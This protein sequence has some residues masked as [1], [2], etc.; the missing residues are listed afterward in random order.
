M[1]NNQHALSAPPAPLR[2]SKRLKLVRAAQEK[3]QPK[4]NETLAALPKT[5]FIRSVVSALP[6]KNEA[7]FASS[8][9]TACRDPVAKEVSEGETRR[10][11]REENEGQARRS[12]L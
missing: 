8:E 6:A 3:L 10:R 2:V 9:G 12:F 5:S 11:K 7:F 1:D 4:S